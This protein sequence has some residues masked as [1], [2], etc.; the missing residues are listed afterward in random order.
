LP[1]RLRGWLINNKIL[2]RFQTGFGKDKKTTDNIFVIKTTVDRYLR[3]KE[4]V[5]IGIWW[6]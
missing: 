2:S 4:A 3:V 1:G 5:F 6:T